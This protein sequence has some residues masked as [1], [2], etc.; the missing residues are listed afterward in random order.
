MK[1]TVIRVCFAMAVIS[2]SIYILGRGKVSILPEEYS[3]NGEKIYIFKTEFEKKGEPETEGPGTE[4]DMS[5][6]EGDSGISCEDLNLNM[7]T[8]E[9]DSGISYGDLNLNIV[10]PKVMRKR[11]IEACFDVH[12]KVDSKGN[13]NLDFPDNV[14]KAFENAVRNAFKGKVSELRNVEFVIPIEFILK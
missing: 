11:N 5:T 14:Q 3:E 13:Y 2:L 12:V 4:L 1:T 6:S 9:G 7:S 10:Y 8:S